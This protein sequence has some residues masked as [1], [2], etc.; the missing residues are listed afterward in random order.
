[1]PEL[2]PE[3]ETLR[4]IVSEE[5]GAAMA[6]DQSQTRSSWTRHPL[7]I[8]IVGFLM[9]SGLLFVVEWYLSNRSAEVAERNRQADLIAAETSRALQRVDDLSLLAHQYATEMNMVL[10]AI[11]R[12]SA[13]EAIARKARYDDYYRAWVTRYQIEARQILRTMGVPTADNIDQDPFYDAIETHLGWFRFQ[14]G[15]TCLTNV[16][17]AARKLEFSAPKDWPNEA[18]PLC[19]VSAREEDAPIAF[20]PMIRASFKGARACATQLVY[21]AQDRLRAHEAVQLAEIGVIT[22][23]PKPRDPKDGFPK[24][25]ETE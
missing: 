19:Q 15:D 18:K 11:N 21:Y 24:A 14:L 23:K 4:A 25:C 17:H 9:T 1:M 20:D 7:I 12:G 5:I 8:T 2:P 16:F 3:P 22:T 13:Q 10:S 6:K